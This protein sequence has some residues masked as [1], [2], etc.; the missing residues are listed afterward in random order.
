MRIIICIPILL[1]LA[2]IS[3]AQDYFYY[4]G[5]EKITLRIL[6][7][8]ILVKFKE[9]IAFEAKSRVIKQTNKVKPITREQ[10]NRKGLMTLE[11]QAGVTEAERK[12]A[13]AALQNRDEIEY[14]NPYFYSGDQEI[15]LT[16]KIIVKLKSATPVSEFEELLKNTKTEIDRQDKYDKTIYIVRT[17]ANSNGN[18]LE[19]AILFFETGKFEFSEPNFSQKI[20]RYT[21][22]PFFADQWAIDNSGQSGGTPG[23]DMKVDEAWAFTTGRED[24]KIAVIDEGVELNHPDLVNNL[25]PGYDATGSGTNGGPVTPTASHGTKVAGLIAAEAN[26]T[27]GIAGVAYNCSLIPVSI[28]IVTNSGFDPIETADAINWAWD[29]G[30]ADVLCNSW[31]TATPSSLIDAAIVNAITWG[32][33]G[34]GSVVLFAAGNEN[35]NM[36]SY[37]ASLSTTIA[38]GATD[39]CDTRLDPSPCDGSSI[40]GGSNRGVGLDFVAPGHKIKTT[41]LNGGYIDFGGTS[42]ATPHA[43]GVAALMLSVNPCLSY[44]DVKRILELTCDKPVYVSSWTDDPIC[45]SSASGRPHGTWNNEMG[46]GRINAYRA[47]QYAS[48]QNITVGS[49]LGGGSDG[50]NGTLFQWEL[51]GSSCPS[52][53]AATYFVYRYEVYRDITFPFSAAPVLTVSSNG[54]SAANPNNGSYW[55]QAIS[56]TNSSARLRTFV[57]NVISSSGQSVGWVPNHPLDVRF[58]Y[59]VVDPA[60]SNIYLQNQNVTGTEFHKAVNRIEAGRNVTNA[61]PVGDYVLEPGAAVTLHAGRQVILQDGFISKPGSVFHAFAYPFFT[62]SQYPY[63]LLDVLGVGLYSGK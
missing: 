43:A 41:D 48:S 31:G 21:S 38:V 63:G 46:Y 37:P 2:N 18:A 9:D 44:T 11:L 29:D 60:S 16:N 50:S 30:E 17:T 27:I 52:I 53:A 15:G 25:L 61:V 5:K 36:V 39:M 1:L 3:F 59:H 8:K 10:P 49:N 47:L 40:G 56:V 20:K 58:S 42:A 45:Y 57:Y 23:A 7:K 62:C 13:I 6:P 14:A 12:R 24:I 26:N 54:F 34:L 51:I 22:D 4:Y 33:Q 32:R 19:I 55:A 35:D 28:D